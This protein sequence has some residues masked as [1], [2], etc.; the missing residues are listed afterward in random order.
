MRED[1]SDSITW[2]KRLLKGEVI[3]QSR[4]VSISIE[5]PRLYFL[6]TLWNFSLVGLIVWVSGYVPDS[7]RT[8]FLKGFFDSKFI[9]DWTTETEDPTSF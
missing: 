7:L 4:Q 3:N 1:L 8:E 5:K 9:W 2:T 6:V